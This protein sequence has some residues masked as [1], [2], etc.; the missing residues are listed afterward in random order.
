L[1][2]KISL[3]IFTNCLLIL[4][5]ALL[6]T[7]TFIWLVKVYFGL[8]DVLNLILLALLIP[9]IYNGNTYNYRF[10]KSLVFQPKKA[11][12][13]VIISSLAFWYW[14]FIVVDIN[15]L[16]ACSFF[17]FMYG[18][19]GLFQLKENWCKSAIPIIL[20]I[21]T[22]P[23][24]TILD[25]YVGFPLRMFTAESISALFHLVGINN[26][27]SSS[28]ITI[29]N[30]AMQIDFSCSGLKG[31]WT[32]VL[33]YFTLTWLK[34]LAINYK[35]FFVFGGLIVLIILANMVRI[36][37]LVYVI[38]ILKLPSV[39]SVIHA[40]LGIIG[41][42]FSCF[43]IYL[44]VN[45]SWFSKSTKEKQI[46]SIKNSLPT[47]KVKFQNILFKLLLI[48]VIFGLSGLKKEEK[49]INNNTE[50][51]FDCPKNW[52]A[53]PLHLTSEELQFIS[54]QE[55][56]L[57]K[58]SFRVNEINGSLLIMKSNKWRGHHNPEFC[59]RAGGN[60][61]T[62][63]KTLQISPTLPIK[64]MAINNSSSG[65]YWFQNNTQTT[66]DFGS[67]IWSEIFHP[68]ENWLMITL[69]FN[70]LESSHS[71]DVM[72]LINQLNTAIANQLNNK[73]L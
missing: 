70:D 47:K 5:I 72:P 51:Q 4:A 29:E 33:F 11:P 67:R 64:W 37:S 43:C 41:F 73:L 63:L 65:C 66:E 34:K 7:P 57:Y 53:K 23:F 49:S 48:A 44:L 59:I 71:I 6:F 54:K 42:V 16:T 9:V 17:I 56:Q 13:I 39:A 3:Q 1:Y 15:I 61:I 31:L 68:S 50:L 30:S 20:I 52:N 14:S 60:Q 12:L 62:E 26:L 36:I 27:Q 32:G 69:I 10:F 25:I 19:F 21:M 35:W 46:P 8:Y 24:G 38:S 58:S 2:K 28:I 45:T 40:P 22:L 18:I 55:C